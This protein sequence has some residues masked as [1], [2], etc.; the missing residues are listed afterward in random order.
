[1]SHVSPKVPQRQD[2]PG[3]RNYVI[4][5]SR[6]AITLLTIPIVFQMLSLGIQVCQKAVILR[7]APIMT[8]LISVT[9]KYPVRGLVS[10]F[11]LVAINHNKR[12]L[13]TSPLNNRVHRKEVMCIIIQVG[14]ENLPAAQAYMKLFNEDGPIR[15]RR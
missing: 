13:L 15:C 11:Y 7:D 12:L 14:K 1:M 5:H 6:L 9:L 4:T 10:D 2:V 8:H 3:R